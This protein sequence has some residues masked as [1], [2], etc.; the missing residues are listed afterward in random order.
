[1]KT[2]DQINVPTDLRYHK[3]HTWLKSEGDTYLVGISDF[4]QDQLGEVAFVDM[5]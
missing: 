2:P 5:P 1:M 4:A 3:E